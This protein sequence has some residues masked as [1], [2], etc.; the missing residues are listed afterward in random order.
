MIINY[1]DDKIHGEGIYYYNNGDIFM[2]IFDDN[3]IAKKGKM[4][5]KNGDEYEGDF[6]DNRL[7][8]GEGIMKYNN[9]KIYFGKWNNNMKNGFGILCSNENDLEKIRIYFKRFNLETIN[10]LFY[11]NIFDSIFIGNFIDDK[12]NGNGVFYIKDYN[13][14]LLPKNIIYTGNFYDDHQF[15]K[16]RIYFNNISYFEAF[17]LDN[18]SIDEQKGGYFYLKNTFEFTKSNFNIKQ[19][20]DFI[21]NKLYGSN[22]L[23]NSNKSKTR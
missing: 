23:T 8:K 7:R 12:K 22:K 5:Y 6:D 18:Y 3:F 15:E 4:K 19:W 1:K 13:N 14:I 21:K 17:W 10:E 16:G 20:I 11:L 9:K 2:G